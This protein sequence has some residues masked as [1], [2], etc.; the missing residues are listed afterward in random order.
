MSKFQTLTVY[1]GSSGH[2][3][4]S[5]RDAALL[6]GQMI[7]KE[8]LHLIYGGMDSGLMGLIAN[9]AL[10]NGA[11]VTGVVPKKLKDSERIHPDLTET[12]LV[13]NLWERK[14][15]MFVCCDVIVALPGGFGTLD[16]CLEVLYWGKLKLHEKPLVLINIDNYWDSLIKYLQ[17]LNDFDERY[18][19][20]VNTVEELFPAL[21]AWQFPKQPG[22]EAAQSA[23]KPDFPHFEDRIL[24]ENKGSIIVENASIDNTYFLLTALGL[25]QLGKHGRR[26]GIL[27]D[28]GQF[29]E[30]VKWF[31]KAEEEHFITPHC[32]SLMSISYHK[33][34]LQTALDRQNVVKIDLQKDKWGPSETR[35]HIKVQEEM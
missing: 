3:K 18:L 2:T 9:S 34:V 14:R 11:Q 13:G 8:N 12:I 31:D 33:Q 35:T 6:L 15:K 10:Q 26:I 5:Y 29:D 4:Q 22:D 1:L 19:I 21:E 27:N 24:A 7:A 20:V 23:D 17:S 30:L 28:K 25:K 32:K 16:E